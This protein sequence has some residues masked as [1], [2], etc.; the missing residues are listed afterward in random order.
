MTTAVLAPLY[1]RI[2]DRMEPVLREMFLEALAGRQ[3]DQIRPEEMMS[4]QEQMIILL[5]SVILGLAYHAVFL[6]WRG[7]TPGKMICGL[8]VVAAG[9]AEG[10]QDGGPLVWRQALTRAMLWVFPGQH[11][12]LWPIRVIDIVLP[13]SDPRNRAL[14]DRMAGTVVVRSR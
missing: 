6:K 13:V 9:A 4:Q 3:P 11:T 12:C 5:V 2:G 7:A 10:E 14:H 1:L 8:K